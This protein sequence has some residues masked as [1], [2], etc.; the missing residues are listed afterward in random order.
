MGELQKELLKIANFKGNY[1]RIADEIYQLREVRQNA[2]VEG[3]E[4]EGIKHRISEMQR[5]LAE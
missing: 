5:F 3:T 1:D 2:L 4:R